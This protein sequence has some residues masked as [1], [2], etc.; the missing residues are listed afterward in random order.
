MLNVAAVV[1]LMLIFIGSETESILMGK[2]KKIPTLEDRRQLVSFL[3]ELTELMVKYKIDE[4]GGAYGDGTDTHGVVDEH[5]F[6]QH[7][8][9][10][11][12]RTSQY[13]L[14]AQPIS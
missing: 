7:T 6:V 12:V 4:I 14:T 13:N 9:G 8:S 5:F 10:I 11:R 1:L 2:G 3:S